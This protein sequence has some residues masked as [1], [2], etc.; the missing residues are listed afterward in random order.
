MCTGDLQLIDDPSVADWIAAGLGGKFGAVTRTVPAG[1]PAYVRICHPAPD[2]D[3]TLASWS[4]VA[5]TTGRQVHA[6][7]QWH[8]L[9]GSR[10]WLNMTGSLWRG[11]NPERGNLVPEVLG[12]L[13]DL[14]AHHTTDPGRCFFCVWEGYGWAQEAAGF[15]PGSRVYL[16]DRDYLAW[17]GPLSAAPKI[18]YEIGTR[19]SDTSVEVDWFQS[20]NLF[21][22]HDR[23][24]CAASEIDFDSTLIGGRA[25]LVDAILATPAFDA[26]PIGPDDSLAYDA[27]KINEVP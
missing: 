8:A 11:E 7:M 9:V 20:P 24:W 13:F 25:E 5:A 15:P 3:G 17:T 6:L 27:D 26:W 12:P 21:W 19:F 2:R 4:E 23:A 18:G 1:Y 10:D 22:P 16:P 14:L